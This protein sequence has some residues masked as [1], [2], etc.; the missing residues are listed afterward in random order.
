[1]YPLTEKSVTPE[2][3]IIFL[4][5]DGVMN[6]SE[7]FRNAKW[8]GETDRI[9]PLA[10]DQLNRI[11]EKTHAKIVISSSWRHFYSYEEIH[12][13]LKKKGFI[14]ETIGETPDVYTKY[15]YNAPRGCEIND[16]INH[17]IDDNKVCT[18]RRYVILDDDSDMLLKQ[19][20]HLILTDFFSGLTHNIA[21]RTIRKL[22]GLENIPKA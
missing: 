13:L 17:C 10:V 22:Q 21:Y 20:E 7:Y 18:Y 19:Q 16:W 14:G 8:K 3:R 9:D 4:D 12:K 5:M 6:N 2:T 15:K 1:M 11:V